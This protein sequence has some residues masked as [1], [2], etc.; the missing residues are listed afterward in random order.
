MDTGTWAEVAKIVS[1][2]L[3][4]V[5][6]ILGVRWTLSQKD[7]SD[8]RTEWWRRMTWSLERTESDKDRE[9]R[10]GWMILGELLDSDLATA[11]E[12]AFIDLLAREAAQVDNETLEEDGDPNGQD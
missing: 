8:R 1:P 3:A 11:T 5:I 4:A 6:T 9:A 12:A 7:E 10:V 2:F